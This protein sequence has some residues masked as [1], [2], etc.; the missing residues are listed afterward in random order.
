MLIRQL[1]PSEAP[2]VGQFYRDAPEYWILAEGSVDPDLKAQEFF[3]DAPTS[4]DPEQSHH[5]GLFLGTRLSGVVELSYGF[6]EPTD[7]YLG[8]MLIGPWAQSM[9]HG[10]AFL[11]HA[12]TLARSRAARHL[13]LA[14]LE[15][16]PRGCAFWE[17]EGFTHTGRRVVDSDTGHCLHR[18][19]K[20]L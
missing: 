14:V 6:P 5:L 17:R 1:E 19:M 10:K 7:A 3:T 4:C 9:G 12:E 18:L 20:L 16:N 15:A 11:K 8:L 2:L 13:Y